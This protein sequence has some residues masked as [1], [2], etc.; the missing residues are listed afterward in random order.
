MATDTRAHMHSDHQQWQSENAF[1]HDQVR[2][3]Q[4][5][6]AEA[7]ESLAGVRKALAEHEMLLEQHAA[8]I[9]LYGECAAAHEHDLAATARAGK[10][11]SPSCVVG[12]HSAE[13]SDHMQVRR[14]HEELKAEHHALLARWKLLPASPGVEKHTCCGNCSH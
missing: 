1:W 6:T 2:E 8:A 14:R 7:I 13:A 9:R 3:W 10:F 5:Q 12:D 4:Q 11:V